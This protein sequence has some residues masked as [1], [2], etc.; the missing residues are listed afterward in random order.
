[1][2]DILARVNEF[3]RDHDIRFVAHDSFEGFRELDIDR[4]EYEV[5]PGFTPEKSS[6]GLW[7]EARMFGRPVATMAA[8]PIPL[9]S[10]LTDHIETEGLYPSDRDRWEVYGPARDICDGVTGMAVFTGG[11]LIAPD[12]R[13]SVVSRDILMKVFPPLTRELARQRWRAPH[14]FFTVKG[15]DR[16]RR[17]AERYAPE[18]LEDGIRWYRDG[19]L[20][21][22]VPR[23][24]GYMS[25][26]FVEQGAIR[27]V[28]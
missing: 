26:G 15:D 14:Y 7:I 4:G 16:G 6:S 18:E 2:S 13:G 5:Y 11:Y 1:M 22:G 28:P 12:L 17:L 10:T 25:A 21:D 27:L 8:Q 3:A 23:V 19:T 24:V 20:M 9:I